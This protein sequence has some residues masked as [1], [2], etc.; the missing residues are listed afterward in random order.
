VAQQ[1]PPAKERAA[2][3]SYEALPRVNESFENWM[4]RLAQ[5]VNEEAAL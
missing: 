2:E 1:H 3:P 5:L 4:A